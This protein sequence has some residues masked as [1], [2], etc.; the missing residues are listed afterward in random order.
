MRRFLLQWL[1]AASV[2]TANKVIGDE[3]SCKCF[4]GDPCWPSPTEWSTLNETA[5]G[6]LITTVPLGSPCHDPTFDAEK[7]QR[8]QS[9]WQY[10]EVQ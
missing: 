2:A 6:R 4:P 8:L 7:C 10:S 1:L 3:P 5:Q 9:Q